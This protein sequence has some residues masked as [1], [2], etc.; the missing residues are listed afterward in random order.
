MEKK[1]ISM[2]VGMILLLVSSMFGEFESR[3]L[4]SKGTEMN[5]CDQPPTPPPEPVG[6]FGSFLAAAAANNS[7]DRRL[8][9]S[10]AFRLASGPSK[11]G[12]GH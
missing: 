2:V 8:T 1:S 12:R 7:G 9:R 5:G 10:F 3:S 6:G 4:R 11:R